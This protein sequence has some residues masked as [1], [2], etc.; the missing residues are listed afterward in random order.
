MLPNYFFRFERMITK[1]GEN[2]KRRSASNI[3]RAK[4]WVKVSPSE[5]LCLLWSL[6]YLRDGKNLVPSFGNSSF[7]FRQIVTKI[8]QIVQNIVMVTAK[9]ED[10]QTS[11]GEMKK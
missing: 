10:I 4:I 6:P 8:H 2:T 11:L 5:F 3:G 9:K 1:R 7:N